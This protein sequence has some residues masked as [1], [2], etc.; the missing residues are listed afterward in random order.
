MKIIFLTNAS[1]KDKLKFIEE[2]YEGSHQCF[3]LNPS[4]SLIDRGLDQFNDSLSQIN[5]VDIG[6][7]SLIKGFDLVMEYAIQKQEIDLN[8]LIHS[9]ENIGLKTEVIDFQNSSALSQWIAGVDQKAWNRMIRTIISTYAESIGIEEICVVGGKN[10]LIKFYKYENNGHEIF[11]YATNQKCIF[12][13]NLGIDFGQE[14]SEREVDEFSS[15]QEAFE[16]IQMKYQI[17]QLY[18]LRINEKYTRAFNHAYQKFLGNQKTDFK[19][20]EW[21]EF[22]N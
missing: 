10:V 22:L 13:Y 9:A 16:N 12:N 21:Q 20:A 8:I 7:Q 2:N 14:T 3:F 19:I 17:F 5:L 6:V 18:P 15:F 11:Y 4:N 1:E